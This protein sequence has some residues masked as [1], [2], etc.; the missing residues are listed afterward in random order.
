MP[1]LVEAFYFSSYWGRDPRA[2]LAGEKAKTQMDT[3]QL[4]DEGRVLWDQK[5]EF[6]DALHGDQGNHFHQTFVSPGVERLLALQPGEHV[7]D[8]ACG[9]GTMARKLAALGAKV[10]AVDFSATLIEKARERNQPAG[11][12]AE[13]EGKVSGRAWRIIFAA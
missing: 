5:A 3:Q 1:S 12:P 2:Y 4:N 6:W 10:T 13:Q 9:N 11:N 7:L 8:V